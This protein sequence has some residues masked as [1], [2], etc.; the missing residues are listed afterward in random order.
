[1]KDKPELKQIFVDVLKVTAK[2][3]LF[4]GSNSIS[5]LYVENKTFCMRTIKNFII[6]AV[7]Y[8]TVNEIGAWLDKNVLANEKFPNLNNL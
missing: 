5:K 1:M 7:Q 8:Y 6:V 2:E 4:S 3:D